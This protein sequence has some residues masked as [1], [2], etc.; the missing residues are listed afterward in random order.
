MLGSATYNGMPITTENLHR[1]K[2][3]TREVQITY[4]TTGY[5]S[6]QYPQ[7]KKA[8]CD[9][10]GITE[11][12]ILHNSNNFHRFQVVVDTS[13]LA[14]ML[15]DDRILWIDDKGPFMDPGNG[16]GDTPSQDANSPVISIRC[17]LDENFGYGYD[18]AVEKIYTDGN[19]I[20]SLGGMYSNRIIVYYL[21]GTTEYIK[22]A[23]A[24]G[25][26][27]IEHLDQWGIE[28]LVSEKPE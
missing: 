10:Y 28:Y 1:I 6:D 8:I 17:L 22:T 12:M 25:R 2:T 21:D 5:T 16:G 19:T 7:L 18:M 26:A 24:S 13:L 11:E 4:D 23:L 3:E 14:S 9:A 20:Y 15:E 27:T